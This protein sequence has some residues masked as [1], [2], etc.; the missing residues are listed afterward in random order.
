MVTPLATP[1]TGTSTATA[2]ATTSSYRPD[3][4]RPRRIATATSLTMQSRPT[5]GSSSTRTR[6]ARSTPVTPTATTMGSQ[7]RDEGTDDSDADEVPDWRDDEQEG[8]GCANAAFTE[9][10]A[11]AWSSTTFG[12]DEDQ[13]WLDVGV[14]WCYGLERG[15]LVR[16]VDAQITIEDD[17]F[18]QQTI[19]D[20][21]LFI[22]FRIPEEGY[23]VVSEPVL[24]FDGTTTLVVRSKVQACIDSEQ[25]LAGAALSAA[26]AGLGHAWKLIPRKARYRLV[27]NYLQAMGR[28]R[29]VTISAFTYQ[30]VNP[31]E[32]QT[33]AA[34]VGV[35]GVSPRH[36][37]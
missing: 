5:A 26:S 23:P 15:S 31:F 33:A 10:T 34:S 28:Y 3:R 32:V 36:S 4:I 2:S 37:N 8:G 21:I 22:T 18:T 30:V 27:E 1:A 13:M 14:S 16:D 17:T 19:L 25:Y 35:A 6:M 20:N 7:Y 24:S 12:G 29:E 9:A 11:T